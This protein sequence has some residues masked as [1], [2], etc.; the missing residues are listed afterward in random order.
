M[1]LFYLALFRII[2]LLKFVILVRFLFASAHQ[3]KFPL[4]LS[5]QKLALKVYAL[6]FS[7][8]QLLHIRPIHR[9][10]FHHLDQLQPFLQT[11]I[12]LK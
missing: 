9:L 11:L 8:P 5:S 6:L 2:M 10:K 12:I 4:I 3:L 1:I 7:V